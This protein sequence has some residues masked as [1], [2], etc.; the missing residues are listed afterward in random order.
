[1]DE[2][3]ADLWAA[4]TVTGQISSKRAMTD[5]Q[6]NAAAVADFLQSALA[7][8]ALDVS[9]LHQMARAALHAAGEKCRQAA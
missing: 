3:Q 1:M 6:H 8:G 7:G 9:Q 4:V 5:R 2:Q